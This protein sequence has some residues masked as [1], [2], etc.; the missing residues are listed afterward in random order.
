MP[1]RAFAE[2]F[3]FAAPSARAGL[4][5]LLFALMSMSRPVSTT[6]L[7]TAAV[8]FDVIIWLLSAP[9]PDKKPAA[10]D[11]TEELNVAV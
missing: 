7:P 6:L 5:M 4:L 10:F 1:M 3:R 9:A 2:P 11:L 8:T